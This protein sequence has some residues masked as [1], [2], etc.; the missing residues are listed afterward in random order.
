[1]SGDHLPERVEIGA[2][3]TG[4]HEEGGEGWLVS[5]ADMMTLLVGFFVILLSFSAVDEEKF[6]M[7]KKAATQEFGGTYHIP[8][9]ELTEH[10]KAELAKLKMGNQV[11]VK[12]MAN[13]VEISF[14]GAVFFETGSIDVKQEGLT[15]LDGL[16]PIMQKEAGDFDVV[17][18]GHTDDVPVSSN[19]K[20]ASNWDLS[21]VR[22]CR[23]L[24]VFQTKGFKKEQL[25]AVGYGEARAIVPNRDAAGVAISLNQSQNRRVV[26][27]L[28]KHVVPTVGETVP[29]KGDTNL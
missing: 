26:I 6:E 24:D 8:Y 7:V 25:T 15:L 18:E 12:A 19:F 4:A 14:T 2:H 5:Y 13:G 11:A 21:S 17:I 23:V 28:L 1:M 16:I 27:K 9:G 10:L 3:V 22:A 29:E 20:Y